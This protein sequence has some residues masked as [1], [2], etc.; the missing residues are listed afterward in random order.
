MENKCNLICVA[1][2]GQ[3]LKGKVLDI[4]Q[5]GLLNAH[6]SLLPEYRGANPTYWIFRNQEKKGGVTIHYIDEGMDTGDY[7]LQKEFDIPYDCTLD[8]YNKT[9]SEI[10]GL[11]YVEVLDGLAT[12]T[13]SSVPQNGEG[14]CVARRITRKDYI[15]DIKDIQYIGN[16]KTDQEG[17]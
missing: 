10:A 3:L 9:I 15:E 6:P 12:S 2:A 7:L 16:E 11:S 8:K 17:N 4:P 1:S 14:R 5:Y 13:I